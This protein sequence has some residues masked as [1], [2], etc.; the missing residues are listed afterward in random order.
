MTKVEVL[1]KLKET[2]AVAKFQ[3]DS[4]GFWAQAFKLYN[5]AHPNDQKS[6]NC[7]HC[8]R[9]VSAWLQS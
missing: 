8:F 1:A 9:V 2:G 5:E 6:P 3:R 4:G 7:G